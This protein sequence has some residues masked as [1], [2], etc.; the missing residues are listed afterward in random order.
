[1]QVTEKEEVYRFIDTAS[2]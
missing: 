1:M 2:I